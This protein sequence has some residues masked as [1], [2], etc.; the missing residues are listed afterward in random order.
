MKLLD[1]CTLLY[2]YRFCNDEWLIRKKI[3]NIEKLN[4]ARENGYTP[5]RLKSVLDKNKIITYLKENNISFNDYVITSLPMRGNKNPDICKYRLEN[6]F[7]RYNKYSKDIATLAHS[8]INPLSGDVIAA[9]GW[10]LLENE[11]GL[12]FVFALMNIEIKDIELLLYNK[13]AAYKSK[14]MS[15][16]DDYANKFVKDYICTYSISSDIMFSPLIYP[17]QK[18]KKDHELLTYPIDILLNKEKYSHSYYHDKRVDFH[19]HINYVYNMRFLF[20]KRI[21]TSKK[22]LYKNLELEPIEIN[23][24]CCLNNLTY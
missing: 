7:H 16:I 19:Q 11:L 20:Y 5:A 23:L 9:K 3:K 21:T 12:L 10:N 18:S 22:I 6:K 15:Q 24:G 4:Q 2:A 1:C 17:I 14:I 8:S 13:N